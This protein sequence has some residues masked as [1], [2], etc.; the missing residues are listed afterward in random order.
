MI[1]NF[2]YFIGRSS[3][4]LML[5]FGHGIGKLPPS[6]QFITG[7]S[8]MG[9]PLPTVFA[10]AAALS[11]FLGALCVGLGFFTRMGAFFV[12]CTMSVAAFIAHAPDPFQKKE[13]ALVYLLSFLL[14][15]AMG[16]GKYSLD[17]LL[18]RK[19]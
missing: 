12:V 4:G 8:G 10:W 15:F 13:L 11:E 17:S 16:S 18:K 3:L 2:L 14:I 7:V 5:A 1:Q 19:F 9:F 6:E